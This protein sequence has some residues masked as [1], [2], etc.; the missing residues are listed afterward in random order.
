[1][2]CAWEW[3]QWLIDT[4]CRRKRIRAALPEKGQ[5]KTYLARWGYECW[6]DGHFSWEPTISGFNQFWSDVNCAPLIPPYREGKWKRLWDT[7][8][9][10]RGNERRLC[11]LQPM[12]ALSHAS[13]WR[14]GKNIGK[15][16]SPQLKHTRGRYEWPAH[17]PAGSCEAVGRCLPPRFTHSL[18]HFQTG[19]RE[20]PHPR[21][22]QGRQ[23]DRRRKWWTPRDAG[24][25]LVVGVLCIDRVISQYQWH[26][27][28]WD[29]KNNPHVPLGF[30]AKHL[31]PNRSLS[32]VL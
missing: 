28:T 1:M 12:R 30:S 2:G 20:F 17:R 5:W 32:P 15:S 16:H 24:M 26:P 18:L 31:L 21:D 8:P 25:M 27:Q 14:M 22:G 11:L 9:V 23:T 29:S 10:E 4:I 3:L 19:I 13:V 7:G 6:L